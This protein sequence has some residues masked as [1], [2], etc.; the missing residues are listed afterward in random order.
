MH[1][2]VPSCSHPAALAA[3]PCAGVCSTVPGALSHAGCPLSSMCWL[4]WCA[5]G[6]CMTHWILDLRPLLKCLMEAVANFDSWG[7]RERVCSLG[8]CPKLFALGWDI[9]WFPA[10]YSSGDLAMSR[11]KLHVGVPY[12]RYIN[13]ACASLAA[14]L[15]RHG[16]RHIVFQGRI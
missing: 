2:S 5:N 7:K 12:W 14:D 4:G 3:L 1:I 8:S 15:T 10:G 13:A 16:E 9:T 11:H 6:L